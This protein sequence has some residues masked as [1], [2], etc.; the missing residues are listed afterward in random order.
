M[1]LGKIKNITGGKDM[2][3][4]KKIVVLAMIATMALSVFAGC[5]TQSGSDTET[6]TAAASAAAGE[7]TAPP[8]P[9]ADPMEIS[10]AMWDIG[11][12]LAGEQDAVRDTLYKK[13]NITIKPLNVTWDDYTQKIQVWAASDQLPDIFAIDVIGTQN[14][15]N[16]IEQG[17]VQALP[18]DLSQYPNLEKW[19]NGSGMDIYKYP[20]NDPNGKFYAIPRLSSFSA[21]EW[22][23]NVGVVIRKDWMAN[24]GITKEPE[25]MDEFIALMKAFVEN[26]PDKNNK[27]DT[28]GLTC[29]NADW[30][31]W[32]FGAYEPGL[33]GGATNWVR[34]AEN[35]GKWIPSFMTK[36]ALEGLKA[37]K[38]LYD[39]GGLDKD[40]AALKG[41][42]GEDKFASGKA[43]AYSHDVTPG[44]LQ[45]LNDKYVK[46][47]P[48]KK[49]EDAISILKPF[50]N[51]ND[52]QYYR[53]IANP[54]WSETL[55]NAKVDAK[56]ADRIMRLFDY[57]IGEE[58]YNLI[59]F[60]IEGSDW[61]KVGDKIVLIPKLDE[62]GNTKPLTTLYPFTKAGFIA[63]WSGTHQY[64]N[65][66]R[67]PE[68]Q[69]MSSD[70]ND[71][72]I[73]NAKPAPIDLRIPLFD[74]PDK[75]KAISAKFFSEMT[76]KCIMSNDVEKTWKDLVNQCIGNG[77]N[78]L[79][80]E[81]N[82][83]CAKL[84]IK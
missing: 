60:G 44:T 1:L 40:F 64:T 65:P 19:M 82:A 48:D 80:E 73:A 43:G 34:D 49:Y 66:S 24:V 9:L 5:G 76:I 68:L 39:A 67:T 45:Y 3:N 10:L 7:T 12:A 29:F 54:A 56:K 59:H 61:K 36:N 17:I 14:Y 84:G 58:G 52:G 50:K 23:N 22:A 47:F 16:W 46:N 33:L 53:Y 21:D 32:F 15:K 20:V 6:T 11:Q 70:M 2:K 83:E 26:D 4:L 74:L 27:K 25:S 30:L 69:K 55:I 77:Y 18:D 37:L 28:I 75:D 57:V 78:K 41:E 8:D 35:P 51:V 71:W 38:R 79:M 13:L 62:A 42:E 81:V 72:M 63:E 31:T